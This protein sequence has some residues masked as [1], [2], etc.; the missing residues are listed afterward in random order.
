MNPPIRRIDLLVRTL[1]V[2]SLAGLTLGV[3]PQPATAAPMPA[4][5]ALA[6]DVIGLREGA[7]GSDVKAVQTALLKAGV[8]VP[9]GADGVFG[10][11][12][13]SA[14]TAFQSRKGLPTTGEIDKAT[15]AALQLTNA[16]T[17]QAASSGTS[18]GVL[19]VG[20]QGAAVVALQ[21]A[22]IAA[23]VWVAG[24]ADGVFGQATKTAVANFQRWNGLE[25]TGTVTPATRKALG[26]DG[27]SPVAAPASPSAPATRT[28]TGSSGSTGSQLVGL[29]LG[30]VGP[31]VKA[32]QTALI[33]AG[34]T[35]RGGADGAFGPMTKS[36]LVSFQQANGLGS[37]GVVDQATADE[38]EGAPATPKPA[39]PTASAN[40]YVG[41]S[42]GANGDRVKELQRALMNSGLVLRGGADGVFG[43]ATKAT[44]IQF[45][46][47]NGTSQSGVVSAKDASLLG[48]GSAGQPQ[49]VT[50]TDGFPT[51]GERGARVTA[52]QK[53]L[54][55]AGISFAG[56]ADGHFGA[57][58]AGAI[59][60]FQRREGLPVTGKVDQATADRLGT[61]AAP[62]PDAP[63]ATSLSIDVFP[64]Q[65]PCWFGDTW[66]A[67]RGGGRLHIGTD[68]IAAS[69]NL[70]YAV[71]DG[72]VSKV[73][74]DFPGALAGNGLRIEKADGSYFT[75]LHLESLADGI[76]L[77]V[78]V[79][80]GQ[81]IGYVG[82]TG[83]SATPHL[84]FE[85]HPADG[86]AINPYQMLKAIDACSVTTPRS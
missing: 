17:P 18:S 54:L 78:P 37:S 66:H 25:A 58:T 12:T 20:A 52:L 50:R 34:V 65:G 73:Y 6:Q 30:A 22:L 57:A 29:K 39:A 2:A 23:G 59:M 83:N 62:A 24:G 15:A 82:N 71:V 84:H 4:T 45:Q 32:L 80:A 48:L 5:P 77:G 63:S 51:Y 69:G 46:K 60:D 72:K 27:G 26:L 16:S 19:A 38:L 36:A 35:V 70:L 53:S 49:G 43:N 56:G 11:A 42:V 9:G 61:A 8:Q 10:P 1:C 79:K 68:I 86:S 33:A 41:L 7:T 64:V 14:V 76:E 47:T 21:K 13:R 31:A 55:K 74:S 28:A 3:L 85:A 81:V 75:Y 44:L 67:P 40:P